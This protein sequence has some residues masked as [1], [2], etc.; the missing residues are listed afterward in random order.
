MTGTPGAYATEADSDIQALYRRHFHDR[1]TERLCLSSLSFFVTFAATRS[2]AHASRN[3]V[4]PFRNMSMG[5]TH[6]HHSFWGIFSL[7]A[8]GYA[9]V[10][11]IGTGASGSRRG[12]RALAALY[13]AGAALTL[14]EYAL[15]LKPQN[16]YKIRNDEYWQGGGRKSIYAVVLFGSF[17][18]LSM[19]G[20]PLLRALLGGDTDKDGGDQDG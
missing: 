9:W 12:M 16:D 8:M 2:L 1:R 4:G 3:K 15:W 13:G 19:G 17:L 10:L 18:L 6:I 20:L 7:L 11:E 5:G 14:D